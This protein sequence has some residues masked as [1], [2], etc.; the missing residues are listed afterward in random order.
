[1]TRGMNYRNLIG[2]KKI[3]NGGVIYSFDRNL[4]FLKY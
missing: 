3:G 2:S 1:M 4:N